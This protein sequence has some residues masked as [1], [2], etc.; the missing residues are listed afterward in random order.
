MEASFRVEA[1]EPY[2]VERAV[3]VR[4]ELEEVVVQ[5]LHEEE[6]D[7]QSYCQRGDH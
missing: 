4:I 6:A 7:C 2:R 5:E 3:L 1:A